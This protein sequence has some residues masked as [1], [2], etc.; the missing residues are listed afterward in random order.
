MDANKVSVRIYGQDYVI[1]GEE[2]SEHIIR[3]ADYVDAKMKEIARS[4]PLEATSSLAV[5]TAVNAADDYY[6]LLDA[7][8]E[9]KNTN[10][11]L[12]A[13]V[14]RYI[15][16]WEEAK[17]SF[18]QY[19]EDSQNVLQKLEEMKSELSSKNEEIEELRNKSK[20]LEEKLLAVTSDKAEMENA[21]YKELESKCFDLEM[22]KVRMKSELERYK[23]ARL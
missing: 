12:E 5:L 6:R 4:I 13:D 14:Q 9:L 1:G 17:K 16:L 22:E 21:K 20:S 2:S 15:Q 19:K 23:R 10:A 18:L 3:V 11:E 8:T 7:E